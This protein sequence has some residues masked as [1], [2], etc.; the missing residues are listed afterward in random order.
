M[1]WQSATTGLQSGFQPQS[2]KV[3]VRN[4]II[5]KGIEPSFDSRYNG[6][7]RVT[8]NWNQV[9][10]AGISLGAMAVYDNYKDSADIVLNRAIRT[11][12]LAMNVYNPDGVYPEGYGYWSYGTAFNVLFIDAYER[13][14]NTAYNLSDYDGFLKT[15]EYLMHMARPSSIAFNYSDNGA[16]LLLQEAQFWFAKR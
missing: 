8:H 6:W 4:A 16:G 5:K 7:L 3:T 14:A 9:C 2:S 15:S 11:L 10:N 13:F 1:A 12:P